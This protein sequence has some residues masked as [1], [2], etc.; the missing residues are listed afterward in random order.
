M[1]QRVLF[2]ALLAIADT[3]PVLDPGTI[4]AFATT[5]PSP[6]LSVDTDGCPPDPHKLR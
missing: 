4:A 5:L 1:C 2:V 3:E 6:A